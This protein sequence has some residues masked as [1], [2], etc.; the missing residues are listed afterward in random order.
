MAASGVPS[1]LVIVR[2]FWCEKIVKILGHVADYAQGYNV[3]AFI[4]TVVL[5]IVFV[6]RTTS[7]NKYGKIKESFCLLQCNTSL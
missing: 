1:S 4:L 2:V 6:P 5:Y 3:H 7:V